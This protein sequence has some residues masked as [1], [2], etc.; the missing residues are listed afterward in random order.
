MGK[1]PELEKNFL[2][3]FFFWSFFRFHALRRLTTSLSVGGF[4]LRSPAIASVGL[5]LKMR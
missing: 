3:S 1:E 4:L 5:E 2:Y